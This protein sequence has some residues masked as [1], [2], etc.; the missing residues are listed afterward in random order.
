MHMEARWRLQRARWRYV[1]GGMYREARCV[2]GGM[3]REARCVDGGMYREARCVDGGMYVG[4]GA[5]A[6]VRIKGIVLVIVRLSLRRGRG[7]GF[8]H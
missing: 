7:E 8:A 2:D 5:I 1:D 3:Y 4:L 6:R